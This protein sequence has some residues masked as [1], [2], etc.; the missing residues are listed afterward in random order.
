MMGG[1]ADALEGA[2]DG[3]PQPQGVQPFSEQV[4]GVEPI[5]MVCKMLCDSCYSNCCLLYSK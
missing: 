3:F 4:A 1:V 5:G 2:F